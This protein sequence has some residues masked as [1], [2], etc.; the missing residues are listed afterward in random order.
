VILQVTWGGILTAIFVYFFFVGIVYGDNPR[1]SSAF[2]FVSRLTQ[3]V[4]P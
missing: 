1:Y 4:L 2:G 3:P